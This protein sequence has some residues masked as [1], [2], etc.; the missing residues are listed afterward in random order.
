MKF[1]PIIHLIGML[2]C[3]L[4]L[5]MLIPALVDW[6]YGSNDW[7]AFIFSALL[8]GLVGALF[9]FIAK[10][11]ATEHLE[12]RQAFLLTNSAW[13]SIA[14]FGSYPFYFLK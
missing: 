13:L 7:P 10:E 6:F 14:L 5:F 4:A 9:Y 2:L 3:I 12:L 8:T 1:A 11:S